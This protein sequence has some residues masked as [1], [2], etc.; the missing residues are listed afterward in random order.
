MWYT[1]RML[2]RVSVKDIGEVAFRS[3]GKCALEENI[4]ILYIHL[5]TCRTHVLIYLFCLLRI[6]FMILRSGIVLIEVI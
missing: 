4:E 3:N 5:R 6:L 2:C 1:V